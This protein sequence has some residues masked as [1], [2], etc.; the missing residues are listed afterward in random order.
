MD[1]RFCSPAADELDGRKLTSLS[2]RPKTLA[3]KQV[4]LTEDGLLVMIPASSGVPR[5]QWPTVEMVVCGMRSFFHVQREYSEELLSATTEYSSPPL[6]YRLLIGDLWLDINTFTFTYRRETWQTFSYRV[7]HK[8]CNKF[9]R[10]N[11]QWW[12]QIFHF[13]IPPPERAAYL[14]Q[15]HVTEG[16]LTNVARQYPWQSIN[17]SLPAPHSSWKVKFYILMK[18]V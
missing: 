6:C 17:R 8:F 16:R 12:K 1:C 18:T 5:V 4:F 2:T 15:I 13:S 14:H 10:H 9:Q 11:S 7:I 3:N